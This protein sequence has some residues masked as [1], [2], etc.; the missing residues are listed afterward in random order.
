MEA[1]QR[2]MM[3]MMHELA[4]HLEYK[5]KAWCQHIMINETIGML[6]LGVITPNWQNDES[7]RIEHNAFNN[8][9]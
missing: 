9:I 5:D 3:D 1:H 8:S 7:L 4:F 2:R 6:F